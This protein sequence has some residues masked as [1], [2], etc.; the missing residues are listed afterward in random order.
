MPKYTR[1]KIEREGNMGRQKRS[2]P[3]TPAAGFTAVNGLLDRRIFLGGGLASL[4]AA[5]GLV[6]GFPKGGP[7]VMWK[8]TPYAHIMV[9]TA[10]MAKSA[11][12]APADKKAADKK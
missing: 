2:L 5:G 10:S 6:L 7:W 9:P 3:A 11:S 8:G 1:Q 12:K 4:G